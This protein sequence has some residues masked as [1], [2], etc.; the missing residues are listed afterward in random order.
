[1]NNHR[2]HMRCV[3]L[4][5]DDPAMMSTVRVT[6]VTLR[7]YGPAGVTEVELVTSLD[8]PPIGTDATVTVEW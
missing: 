7:G 6:R 1:M 2:S 4:S 5:T 8:P 3:E